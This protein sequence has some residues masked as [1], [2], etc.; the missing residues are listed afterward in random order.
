MNTQSLK[1]FSL[2]ESPT[3][4]NAVML[5]NFLNHNSGI[6]NGGISVNNNFY[7]G[8]GIANRY[9]LDFNADVNGNISDGLSVEKCAQ[10][11][12]AILEANDFENTSN[13]YDIEVTNPLN[14]NIVDGQTDAVSYPEIQSFELAEIE[15]QTVENQHFVQNA[16]LLLGRQQG[17]TYGDNY[18]VINGKDGAATDSPYSVSVA[19]PTIKEG[20]SNYNNYVQPYALATNGVPIEVVKAGSLT[21]SDPDDAELTLSMTIDSGSYKNSDNLYSFDSN[22]NLKPFVNVNT[23]YERAMKFILSKNGASDNSPSQTVSVSSNLNPDDTQTEDMTIASAVQANV[24]TFVE[25]LDQTTSIQ[26]SYNLSN[27][28]SNDQLVLDSENRY[29]IPTNT[30]LSTVKNAISVFNENSAS[31]NTLSISYTAPGDVYFAPSFKIDNIALDVDN[32]SDIVETY[33]SATLRDNLGNVKASTDVNTSLFGVNITHRTWG[34]IFATISNVNNINSNNINS[35]DNLLTIMK[36]SNNVRVGVKSKMEHGVA[37]ESDNNFTQKIQ[38]VLYYGLNNSINIG[39]EIIFTNLTLTNSTSTRNITIGNL[40]SLLN[41]SINSNLASVVVATLAIPLRPSRISDV[42]ITLQRLWDEV[43]GTLLTNLQVAHNNYAQDLK[44]AATVLAGQYEGLS[45]NVADQLDD[46]VARIIADAEAFTEN[47]HTIN[48]AIVDDGNRWTN[49][50]I[51]AWKTSV[52]NY[53]KNFVHTN[54]GIEDELSVAGLLPPTSYS[55]DLK[56]LTDAETAYNNGLEAWQTAWNTINNYGNTEYN[57][58]ISYAIGNLTMT[59]SSSS[60]SFAINTYDGSNTNANISL[61][62]RDGSQNVSSNSPYVL[63]SAFGW[64]NLDETFTMTNSIT[65]ELKVVNSYNQSEEVGSATTNSSFTTYSFT[66]RSALVDRETAANNLINDIIDEFN[67][68]VL[69]FTNLKEA[70]VAVDVN[71][72][73]ASDLW[74][75]GSVEVINYL[76]MDNLLMKNEYLWKKSIENTLSSTNSANTL[77]FTVVSWDDNK[78]Q[79]TNLSVTAAPT[80]LPGP[81]HSFGTNLT[82]TSDNETWSMDFGTDRLFN[83]ILSYQYNLNDTQK[84]SNDKFR[85]INSVL[86]SFVYNGRKATIA[87]DGTVSVE[88]YTNL[89][90]PNGESNYTL[91]V[92]GDDYNTNVQ[93]NYDNSKVWLSNNG[94][95]YV[96]TSLITQ[97]SRNDIITNLFSVNTVADSYDFKNIFINTKGSDNSDTMRLYLVQPINDSALDCKVGSKAVSLNVVNLKENNG[98]ISNG[99]VNGDYIEYTISMK[100]S[101][102]ALVGWRDNNINLSYK[103]DD[104]DNDDNVEGI[105]WINIKFRSLSRVEDTIS[106]D[107]YIAFQI[108]QNYNSDY[109]LYNYVA[110]C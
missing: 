37:N 88:D 90:H 47:I 109:S 59:S 55:A 10:A 54:V 36:N 87:S 106:D 78:T 67:C 86:N 91:T 79:S 94:Y 70:L 4:E 20:I 30:A 24:Q 19:Y 45:S 29:S 95:L 57:L 56:A 77:K 1:N 104:A 60:V 50:H 14:P 98:S 66:T 64:S 32:T 28:S 103:S 107:Q 101:V 74:V 34:D 81:T 17:L 26:Q 89:S 46:K 105:D 40:A 52:V 7:H 53:T 21:K 72:I 38:V 48:A 22:N 41:I 82:N 71:Q 43:N 62:I 108:A 93:S 63:M 97:P 27:L 76:D 80:N 13:S 25:T 15:H 85:Y 68:N 110:E 42:N 96:V 99:Q 61:G 8:N 75:N 44:D 11:F 69:T 83:S 18:S 39:N 102:D 6:S 35:I 9:L 3:V 23:K 51:E 5:T 65:T 73:T 58:I 16:V 84:S 12:N 49:D 100:A 92:E 33:F 2:F 31:D